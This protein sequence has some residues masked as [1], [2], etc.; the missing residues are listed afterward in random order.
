MKKNLAKKI[1]ACPFCGSVATRWMRRSDVSII[2]HRKSCVFNGYTTFDDEHIEEIE[3][4]NKR[5]K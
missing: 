4:W 3:T 1:K 5:V 2:R